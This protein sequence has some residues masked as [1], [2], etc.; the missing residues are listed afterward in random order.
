MRNVSEEQRER[1]S[2][3]LDDALDVY[4]EGMGEGEKMSDRLSAANKVIDLIGVKDPEVNMDVV[5]PAVVAALIGGLQGFAGLLGSGQT[6][7]INVTDSSLTQ[8]RIIPTF[9]PSRNSVTLPDPPPL[10]P[11]KKKKNVSRETSKSLKDSSGELT[12]QDKMLME[13]LKKKSHGKSKDSAI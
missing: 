4:E 7:M 5:G 13:G 3:L 8:D 6:K 12:E 10:P 9:S 1:V 2:S 11:L